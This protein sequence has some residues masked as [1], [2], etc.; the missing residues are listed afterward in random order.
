M[1]WGSRGLFE[2]H[3]VFAAVF[4]PLHV[5]ALVEVGPGFDSDEIR[6]D[7]QFAMATIH[8]HSELH[9]LGSAVVVE[10]VQRGPGSASREEHVID[11]DHCLALKIERDAGGVHH[12]R[13]A[14]VE[15]VTV[16]RNI[17][18]T[19]G[20]RMTPD[21][22]EHR[23]QPLTEVPS[24][25]LDADEGESFSGRIPLG[26]FMGDAIQCSAE[27]KAIEQDLAHAGG[28]LPHCER[29]ANL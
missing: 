3:A 6:L 20:D 4:F 13:T 7:R 15:V 21:S 29:Q 23:D 26:D 1:S 19:M 27:L 14:V 17:Q 22:F 2:H 18:L 24:A 8:E 5:D 9:C 11:E 10:G 25:A 28:N 12:E 16:H